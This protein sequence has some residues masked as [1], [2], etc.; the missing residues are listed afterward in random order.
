MNYLLRLAGFGAALLISIHCASGQ[1][2]T[3]ALTVDDLPF[4][5]GHDSGPMTAADG[6]ASKTANHKLLA[7]FAR[8]RVPVTG[9]VIQKSVE[10]LGAEG[11]DAVLRN[12]V[13]RG[14]DLGNHSYE[15]PDFNDL[16]AEQF[17]DQV[18]RGERVFAPL[19]RAAG[20][21][22]EFFRF[23]FNHTGDTE[24]KHDE[25]AAFLVQRGYRLAP[26]TIENSDW[27]FNR[28]YAKML[29]NHDRDSAK[30]L[31]KDYEAFTAAQIDYF[32]RLNSQVLGYEPPEILLLHDNQLNADVIEQILVLF[33]QRGFQW[34]SLSEAEK[35]PIYRAP[36]TTITKYGPMWGYRWAKARGVKV[37]GSLEPEPPRWI[38]EY[39][40]DQPVAKR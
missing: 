20:R 32:A 18:V 10:E 39:G 12:W 35:D 38:T 29:A 6:K 9:F 34:V 25:L 26:C 24:A 22:P 8:H 11:G 28:A 23:P 15:H 13:Q 33:E 2:H 4:V 21:R 37:D 36:D 17:E 1:T 27:L 40:K 5:A 16:T 14:F 30:R 31:R 19:M 3:V 7:A